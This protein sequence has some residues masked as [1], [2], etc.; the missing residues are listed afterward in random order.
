M[1]NSFG[2]IIRVAVVIAIA[3][4]TQSCKLLIKF[5]EFRP[6]AA[7]AD[8]PKP[9]AGEY[10]PPMGKPQLD[11][12]VALS[13]GGSRSAYYSIGVLKALYD[14]GYLQDVD[15]LSA[16]SGGGYAL[17][18]L[19]SQNQINYQGGVNQL[20]IIA[21]SK[22][23]PERLAELAA[24]KF[25]E[26]VFND[27]QWRQRNSYLQ[28]KSIVVP[29]VHAFKWSVSSRKA[30]RE[31]YA[32]YVDRF[33][34]CAEGQKAWCPPLESS[35]LLMDYKL[36]IE[37]R[38]I[39]F[40]QYN[41][42]IATKSAIQWEGLVQASPF[43]FGNQAFGFHAWER[44]D[45]MPLSKAVGISGAAA[46]VILPHQLPDYLHGR[47]IKQF[48]MTAYDGAGADL[49]NEGEKLGA[50]SL[51]ERGVRNVIILDTELDP[52]YDFD[53][54]RTLKK[55]A[56]ERGIDLKIEAIDKFVPPKASILPNLWSYKYAP[57]LNLPPVMA[58]TA[59]AID[60]SKAKWSGTLNIR[61]IKM[62]LNAELFSY[63][64]NRLWGQ[65]FC[66]LGA[67]FDA[68]DQRN[69]ID[70]PFSTVL[71]NRILER[72]LIPNL[73]STPITQG[74]YAA[75]VVD[76]A[77]YLESRYSAGSIG[78][79]HKELSK[80]SSYQFPMM[81]TIDQKFTPDQAEALI[82]L[83]FLQGMRIDLGNPQQVSGAAQPA[84][85]VCR[86]APPKSPAVATQ[87][88]RSSEQMQ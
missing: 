66:A 25:G 77:N 48:G 58:G 32:F 85:K 70:R 19:L 39:P 64:T 14:K 57:I 78:R 1:T 16:V 63:R 26:P 5:Q 12:A 36:A 7:P 38:K 20:P 40:F 51:L 71:R 11:L 6:Y 35:P 62:A 46:P 17:Y 45:D 73:G 22:P 23:T 59:T 4:L 52:N 3:S 76:Y 50:L 75:A 83:G 49:E 34:R 42:T 2:R 60:A 69:D 87:P 27:T 88:P 86:S 13:G 10:I 55:L 54:Y 21:S 31:S 53:A 9:E 18:W 81:S 41:F 37:Q 29:Y 30:L 43:R 82:G 15:M 28:L 74:H 72:S 68:L 65:R 80:F 61:Y 56:L 33:A 44:D 47:P 79:P 24:T 84:E 67:D 8:I